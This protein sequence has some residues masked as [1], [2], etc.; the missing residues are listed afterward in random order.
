MRRS[1]LALVA[2]AVFAGS[3]SAIT[4]GVPDGDAHPYVGAASSG[5][6]AKIRSQL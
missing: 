3:A 6:W 2:A 4:N 5:H 1:I